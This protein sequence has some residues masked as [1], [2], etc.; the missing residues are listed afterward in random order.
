MRIG[1]IL[2]LLKHLGFHSISTQTIYGGTFLD[3]Y[4]EVTP[5]P[6]NML[7]ILQFIINEAT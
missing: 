3:S 5:I 4:R 7:N 6:Y 2:L 1:T